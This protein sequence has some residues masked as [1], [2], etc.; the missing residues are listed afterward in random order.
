MGQRGSIIDGEAGQ[1]GAHHLVHHARRRLR[2]RR[3]VLLRPGEHTNDDGHADE[4]DQ[5]D[6]DGRLRQPAVTATCAP[7][8]EPASLPKVSD[9]VR[10]HRYCKCTPISSCGTRDQRPDSEPGR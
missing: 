8:G 4:R 9:H 1:R 10:E 3:R 2:T 6:H 5:D 7:P